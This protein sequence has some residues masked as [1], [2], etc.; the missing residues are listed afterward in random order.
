MAL[1]DF[2]S[3]SDSV[4]TIN[5]T[6]I[7][8]CVT[9][10]SIQSTRRITDIQPIGGNDVGKV[11]GSSST[12]INIDGALNDDSEDIFFPLYA[13]GDLVDFTR[14]IVA[15]GS[16]TSCEAYIA[17]YNRD[18][19]GDGYTKFTMTLAVAGTVTRT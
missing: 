4:V 11:I 3:G 2:V 14:I 7:S 5:A 16:T 13:A 19:P 9:G 8:D 17:T 15:T 18:A 10:S 1:S 12:T 6:D